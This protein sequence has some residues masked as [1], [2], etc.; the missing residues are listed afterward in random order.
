MRIF[1]PAT[2]SVLFLP[3]VVKPAVRPA[4][5]RLHSPRAARL[6]AERTRTALVHTRRNER[7]RS[8]KTRS[9][10]A[11]HLSW[12]SGPR[13][14]ACRISTDTSFR[15]LFFDDRCRRAP[16]TSPSRQTERTHVEC[17]FCSA[18][19]WPRP[20]ESAS[21]VQATRPVCRRPGSSTN[22]GVAARAR[23]VT[24]ECHYARTGGGAASILPSGKIGL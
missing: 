8:G 5:P 21:R 9:V 23:V 2:L 16:R 19:T 14:R 10:A 20:H 12:F 24:A 6:Q 7:W 13:G 22:C 1:C 11:V 4:P 18:L 17:W 3:L 15:L